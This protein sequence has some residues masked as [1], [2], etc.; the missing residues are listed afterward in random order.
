MFN[1]LFFNSGVYIIYSFICIYILTYII[2][3]K[4]NVLY[5]KQVY[6]GVYDNYSIMYFYLPIF[7]IFIMNYIA[8][9]KNK[10]LV[11]REHKKVYLHIVINF[12]VLISIILLFMFFLISYF[13]V[14]IAV[15]LIINI[16]C[17]TNIFLLIFIIVNFFAENKL[18]RFLPLMLYV[19]EVFLFEKF[20]FSMLNY[21][22]L[23]INY[24]L[25]IYLAIF[26]SLF[27]LI[28]VL[29]KASDIVV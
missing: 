18:L 21:Y 10:L 20:K 11:I 27:V 2:L 19:E 28:L 22:K 17:I 23:S 29:N 24:S 14:L 25:P 8:Q 13:G 6:S 26:I 5:Y 16:I 9:Y 15:H 3:L 4:T 12:N 1:K 7:L